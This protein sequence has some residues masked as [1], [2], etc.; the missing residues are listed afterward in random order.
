M[1]T[2]LVWVPLVELSND[3]LSVFKLCGRE[4]A[5]FLVRILVSAPP[6]FV[7]ELAMFAATIQF[8]VEDLRNLVFKFPIHLDWRRRRLVAMRNLRSIVR[9]EHGDVEDRVNSAERVG[10]AES[11]GNCSNLGND[12]VRAKV[13]FRELL[14][15]SGCAEELGLDENSVAHL[16]VWRR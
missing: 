2:R 9:F 6:H 8:G 7:E 4:P 10:E 15:R 11:V 1:R 13:S 12:L 14:G 5:A 3:L 16:E